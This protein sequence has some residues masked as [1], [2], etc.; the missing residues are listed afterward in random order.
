MNHPHTN[1]LKILLLLILK[2]FLNLLLIPRWGRFAVTPWGKSPSTVSGRRGRRWDWLRS[3][4][5]EEWDLGPRRLLGSGPGS[6]LAAWLAL[7]WTLGGQVTGV[8]A[9][10]GGWGARRERKRGTVGSS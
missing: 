10:P 9:W 8:A 3:R 4:L 2:W 6:V 1:T 5:G 7:I